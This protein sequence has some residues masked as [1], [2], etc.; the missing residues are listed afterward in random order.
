MTQREIREDSFAKF[1]AAVA[2]ATAAGA[3]V[4]VQHMPGKFVAMVEETPREDT[5]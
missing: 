1:S 2:D 3:R 5:A 4:V